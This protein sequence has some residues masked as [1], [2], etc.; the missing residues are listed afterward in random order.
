MM[1]S[2]VLRKVVVS[3]SVS[4]YQLRRGILFQNVHCILTSGPLD[5]SQSSWQASSP[6]LS[7]RKPFSVKSLE[8]FSDKD[9]V[10]LSRIGMATRARDSPPFLR[11]LCITLAR[12]AGCSS[13]YRGSAARIICPGQLAYRGVV[14]ADLHQISCTPL[15]PEPC[16]VPSS[17]EHHLRYYHRIA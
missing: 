17:P 13:S 8:S 16:Q 6:E 10:V 1:T 2:I 5:G 14:Q 9:L 11:K 3:G 4:E 7:A 15:P 12:S